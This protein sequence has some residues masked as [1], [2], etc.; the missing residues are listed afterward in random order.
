MNILLFLVTWGFSG[1]WEPTNYFPFGIISPYINNQKG[2]IDSVDEIRVNKWTWDR[3]EYVIGDADTMD[4]LVDSIW[5]STANNISW[6][7]TTNRSVQVVRQFQYGT[8]LY[9][10]LNQYCFDYGYENVGIG[11]L[12]DIITGF[13]CYHYQNNGGCVDHGYQSRMVSSTNDFEFGANNYDSLGRASLNFGNTITTISSHFSLNF[14]AGLGTYDSYFSSNF[15][16]GNTSII[17]TFNYVSGLGL[18]SYHNWFSYIRGISNWGAENYCDFLYGQESSDSLA[19]FS[20]NF[21]FSNSLRN[22]YSG[23]AFGS[24]IILGGDATQDT[25]PAVFGTGYSNSSYCILFGDEPTDSNKIPH[26]FK[27]GMPAY[28]TNSITGISDSMAGKIV[29]ANKSRVAFYLA[30]VDSD[31]V[32]TLTIEN[33]AENVPGVAAITGCCTTD[34]IIARTWTW[35]PLGSW[36]AKKIT[37]AV[38]YH[39]IRK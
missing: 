13:Q 32:V 12:A 33:R 9:D 30:G 2:I 37:G 39:I 17:D 16:F 19:S 6:G 20:F 34:S 8:N 18:F 3:R 25:F 23:L 28:F 1:P 5:K 4:F 29:F 14:G 38:Q 24:Y 21:G 35:D 22:V 31:D 15:G 26:S 36:T 7:A 11:N 27:V 10:S